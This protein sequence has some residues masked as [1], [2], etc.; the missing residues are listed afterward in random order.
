VSEKGQYFSQVDAGRPVLTGHRPSKRKLIAPLSDLPSKTYISTTAD[1][2]PELLWIALLFHHFGYHRAIRVAA[3]FRKALANL[4]G[5]RPWSRLSEIAKLT[6]QEWDELSEEEGKF[7]ADIICALRPLLVYE[8]LLLEFM[9]GHELGAD[10]ALRKLEDC[11]GR[12]WNR[13]ETPG[14]ATIGTFVFLEAYAGN[15]A[16]PRELLEGL[17]SIVDDPESDQAEMAASGARAMTLAFW[18]IDSEQTND[19]PAKFWRINRALSPC[20]VRQADV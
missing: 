20:R 11:V 15:I 3:P 13:F 10:E 16:A 18:S 12:H 6:I 2:F 14:A 4:D 9:R 1:I 5:T 8:P 19:W 7:K 17:S